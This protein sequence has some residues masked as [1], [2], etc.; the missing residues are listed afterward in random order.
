MPH[1]GVCNPY[2]SIQILTDHVPEMKWEESLI[3][4]SCQDHDMKKVLHHGRGWAKSCLSGSGHV[5]G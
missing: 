4:G 5:S 1:G 2:F 3:C